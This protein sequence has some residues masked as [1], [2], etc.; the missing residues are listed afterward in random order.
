MIKLA[1]IISSNTTFQQIENEFNKKYQS[2]DKR[3]I[4]IELWP[5]SY[6]N[7][8][9]ELST[10]R[11]PKDLRGRGIGSEIMKMIIDYADNNKKIIGLTPSKDFG[12]SSVNRLKVFY[13]MFGFIENKGRNKDFSIS[14]SMIRIPK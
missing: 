8:L 1:E 6:R 12:A 10:I 13:K 7:D 5:V 4:V 2:N 9:L 11:I 14:S 3:G